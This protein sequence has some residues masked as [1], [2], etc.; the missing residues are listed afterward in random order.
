V[1]TFA[2]VSTVWSDSCL[3]FFYSRCPPC[4]AICSGEGART[5]LP[6]PGG[7]GATD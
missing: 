4:P 1:G 6:V 5:L 2:T 3:L 7:V